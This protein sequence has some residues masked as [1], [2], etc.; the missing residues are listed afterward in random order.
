MHHPGAQTKL[1]YLYSTGQG[2]QQSNF[3]A[4]KWW[5]MAAN[6]GDAD[7]Q[8]NL[9][10]LYRD[11]IGVESDSEVSLKWFHQAAA[12]GDQVSAGIVAEYQRTGILMKTFG[13]DV[14]QGR[15]E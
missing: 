5:Q 2:V 10:V 6:Q 15:I 7:A 4:L 14:V 8:Y 11:G 3:E 13:T 12:N 1:A 9:G